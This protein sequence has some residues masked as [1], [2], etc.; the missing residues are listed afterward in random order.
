MSGAH[1]APTAVE[2]AFF[3]RFL[4]GFS[5]LFESEMVALHNAQARRPVQFPLHS[6][7]VHGMI[8][9]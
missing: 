2:M 9:R 8:S 1:K 7:A 4:I 3:K 5:N 6:W